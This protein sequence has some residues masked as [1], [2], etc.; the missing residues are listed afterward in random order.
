[1]HIPDAFVAGHINIAT[2]AVA[3]ATLAWCVKHVNRHLEDRQV[4]LLGVTAAFVFAAQM[5]N[6]PVAAGTSGHFMGALLAALLLGPAGAYLVMTMVLILQCFGFA[7]GGL[8]ALG[9]NVFNM[10]LLGCGGGYLVFAICRRLLPRTRT[11]F[12]AAAAIAAWSSLMLAATACAL[13][14]ALSGLAPLHIILPAMVGVHA[15]IGIGE[16]LITVTVLSTVLA[17]RPDLIVAWQPEKTAEG[18]QPSPIG[19]QKERAI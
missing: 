11:A 19:E 15:L 2:A 7:D 10:A 16:A 1:M 4:P 8:T 12:L 14:L 9:S 3:A 17:S 13:E 18:G 6:F 5:L